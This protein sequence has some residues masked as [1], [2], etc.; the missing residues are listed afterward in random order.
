ME[1]VNYV[2]LAGLP[3]GAERLRRKTSFEVKIRS[4]APLAECTALVEDEG[5]RLE[6]ARPQRA[7][8]PGQAA[9][10]YE[11]ETVALGGTIE[12]AL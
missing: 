6:F 12:S 11:G 5:I 9:V 3:E 8:A 7:V 2:A 10:C 1:S 4:G